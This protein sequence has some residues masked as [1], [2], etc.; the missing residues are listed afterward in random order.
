MAN[1]FVSYNRH[2]ETVVRGVVE[3]VE[4]L[5]H[6]VWF[7]QE[8]TGGQTWWDQILA[9]IRAC[10]L[11]VFVLDPASLE[12][13]A[14]TREYTYAAQ[15]GKTILPLLV[16]DGVSVGLLPDELSRVQYVDVRKADRAATLR[17]ARALTG[18][19]PAG[20]LP[21]P[22]P[23]PPDVP[24]SYL[25]SL[26]RLV[27]GVAPLTY[28]QQS[29][30]LIDLRKALRDPGTRDDARAHGA[31]SKTSRPPRGH[32][33]RDA[34]DVGRDPGAHAGSGH[35]DPGCHA[36]S[37]ARSG[38]RSDPRARQNAAGCD[39]SG[40]C[41]CRRGSGR[42]RGSANATHRALTAAIAYDPR[43]ARAQRGDRRDHR[44]GDRRRGDAN[45][46]GC[47][48]AART[49]D[50]YWC[51]G[52]SGDRRSPPQDGIRCVDMR[53]DRMDRVH[54]YLALDGRQIGRTRRRRGRHLRADRMRRRR[55]WRCGGEED[56]SP[57]AT[58]RAGRKSSA[59]LNIRASHT[60]PGDRDENASVS[61]ADTLLH[62]TQ[63]W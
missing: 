37:G 9:R 40:R 48:M 43:P 51:W 3:D 33:R 16:A 17:L 21:D 35:A 34:R 50:R 7:D 39:G 2:S 18:I 57:S 19:S 29:G 60:F 22:L 6:V 10:D 13:T 20:P 63:L 36:C 30:L 24:L 11:F 4:A 53:R 14:C 23:V 25:A 15:L 31:P 26:G 46:P 8:L 38:P 55:H 47:A 1:I 27:D 49:S 42:R 56:T 61:C 62:L 54:G 45:R 12:S 32:C 59:S 58:H 28:E 44:I 41:G 5:G 52:S